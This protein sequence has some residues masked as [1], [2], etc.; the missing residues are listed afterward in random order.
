MHKR[1]SWWLLIFVSLGVIIPFMAPYLMLDPDSSRVTITSKAIQ[2]PAL[3]THIVFAFIAL[4]TGFFQF[5]DR[6]HLKKPKLHRFLGRTYVGSIVI[7]SLLSLVVVLYIDNFTK[8]VAFLTLT[9]LWLFTT[10]KGYRKAV[11]RSFNEHRKWMI[12][13]F[14]VTLV[15]VS[16][17]IVVPVLLLAYYT[18]NGFTFPDGRDKMIEEVLHVNIWI[19]IVLNLVIV[20]WIILK[21]PKGHKN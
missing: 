3:V 13:S 5:V 21:S 8:S 9:I 10:L 1:K 15:A 7:S 12:R 20:E 17:R 19:G 16:G 14:G 2:Y 18:L 6:F 4:V 11:K